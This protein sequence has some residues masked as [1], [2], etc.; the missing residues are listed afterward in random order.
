ME[1][2]IVPLLLVF[3]LTIPVKAAPT[4]QITWA[5]STIEI[6]ENS[7][8]EIIS[9]EYAMVASGENV[10]DEIIV[11]GRPTTI[12]IRDNSGRNLIFEN[13]GEDNTA[14]IK[15]F[16][17]SGMMEGERY[18]VIIELTKPVIASDNGLF[19]AIGYQW[20]TSP[21]LSKISVTLPKFAKLLHS[22]PSPSSI[23]SSGDS[24]SLRWVRISE[25]RLQ[26]EM[27]FQLS[28]P[29]PAPSESSQGT[30]QEGSYWT[31]VPIGAV[32]AIL[33]AILVKMAAGR[34]V[35]IPQELTRP[36][37]LS[38]ADVEKILN[39]LTDHER[40]VTKELLREDNLLQKTICERTG[41]PKATLS[42][43]M[44]RLE[45]KGIIRRTGFGAG[46]RVQLTRWGKKLRRD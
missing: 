44:K 8:K 33:L 37:P 25:S 30:Q 39:L 17:S 13:R 10:S 16:F 38:S 1:K 4:F 40:A 36:E 11:M 9:I 2:K 18:T 26:A 29:P 23:S 32:V 21:M 24:I 34:K 20:T 3:L 19:Y 5:E 42:R 31:L 28:S 12:S 14:V 43:T 45:A 27:T 15:F 35:E 7:A 41:I 46:K 6:G 22:E